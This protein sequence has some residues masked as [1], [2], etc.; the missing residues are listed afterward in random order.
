MIDRRQDRPHTVD[1]AVD[2]AR[3]AGLEV[4]GVRV[5]VVGRVQD[6][7][8]G[9]VSGDLR[10]WCQ[11]AGSHRRERLRP[12]V[13][14]WAGRVAS[15]GQRCRQGRTGWV[16]GR[17]GAGRVEGRTHDEISAGAEAS[18]HDP[19]IGPAP[20]TLFGRAVRQSA[21]GPVVVHPLV[22]GVEAVGHFTDPLQLGAS[23][24]VAGARRQLRVI[25]SP[26]VTLIECRAQSNERGQSPVHPLE[27]DGDEELLGHR[28]LG[29]VGREPHRT[30]AFAASSPVDGSQREPE[31]GDRGVDACR[32]AQIDVVRGR[33]H[34][35]GRVRRT[36]GRLWARQRQCGP[37]ESQGED[38]HRV[39]T[40][41][42]TAALHGRPK[43]RSPTPACTPFLTLEAHY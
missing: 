38:G 5:H 4:V 32:G 18:E 22:V 36:G 26:L 2:P 1:R 19:A 43:P 3:C 10:Q 12:R 9:L 29:E 23:V 24:G 27:V 37:D 42:S 21:P 7:G 31:A 33:G 15:D 25:G 13:G 16:P 40:G 6:P 14:K 8:V 30:D 20:R 39:P 11:R 35:S 34:R 28:E 41:P 17:A